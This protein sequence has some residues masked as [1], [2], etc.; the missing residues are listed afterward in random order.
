M[1]PIDELLLDHSALDVSDQK[2][3]SGMLALF[4]GL[5]Q[6]ATPV[7]SFDSKSVFALN[8]S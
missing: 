2:T 8:L 3:Q 4:P 5:E 7:Q 6:S 1:Y